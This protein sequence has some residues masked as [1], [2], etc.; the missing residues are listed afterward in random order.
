[1]SWLKWNKPDELSRLRKLEF[2]QN[3]IKLQ[4]LSKKGKEYELID[5]KQN[6]EAMS[7]SVR[8]RIRRGKKGNSYEFRLTLENVQ[9]TDSGVYVCL[10][11]NKYG[12]DYRKNVVQVKSMKGEL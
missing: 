12:S 6:G 11:R 3:D 10:V 9:E 5:S 8:A 7:L 4:T 2:T 1:M